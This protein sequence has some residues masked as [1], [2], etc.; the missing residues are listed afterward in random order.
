VEP[1]TLW[2]TADAVL[3]ELPRNGVEIGSLHLDAPGREAKSRISRPAFEGNGDLRAK[4][5]AGHAKA[6]PLAPLVSALAAWREE[7][8]RVFLV[9][10]TA[11]SGDR[12]QRLLERYQRPLPL[13]PAGLPEGGAAGGTAPPDA[14]IVVGELS[15][16]FRLPGERVVYVTETEIFGPRRRVQGGAARRREA[17]KAFDTRL[18]DL[19]PGDYL[20]H[21]D[22][23]VA[24]YHG[25]VHL[26][27]GE[28]A[29]DFLQLGFAGNDR[30]YLPVRR[31]HLV[32]RYVG[33]DDTPPRLDRLGGAAWVRAKGK[34]AQAVRAMARELLEVHAARQVMRRKPFG[35]ADGGYE[36]FAARFP[37][38]ET[39]DQQN[40]IEETL[41][42]L[43]SPHPMDRLICGDV[44]YG[45]TEVAMRAAHRVVTGGKQVAVLVPTTVLALQHYQTFKE[46]FRD[47]PVLI[48]EL[49]RFK[50]PRAQ[51]AIVA[52][53]AEGKVDIV[54]GTHRLLGKDVAYRDLGLLVVDEE[55][56]FGVRHK[57]QMKQIR[58]LVDV[59]TLTA[60]PN[61]RTLHMGLLGLRDLS[62][63]NTPPE[64]RL[65]IRTFVMHW[66]GAEAA[67]AIRREI[68][69]GGQVFFVHNRVRTIAEA[70]DRVKRLVPEARIAVAHGQMPERQL[71]RVMLAFQKGVADV[72]VST[73]IIENGL[74]LPNVNTLLVDRA[75]RFGLAQLYQMRG[76][77]GRG[78][79]RAYA[80]LFIPRASA[81][82]GDA[83]KR[84]VALQELVELGSAFKL[85]AQDLEIRGAGNLLGANQSGHI[86]AVGY[87]MFA[88][89]LE[90]AVREMRGQPLEEEV[91]VEIDLKIPAFIP[92]AFVADTSQRLAIYR[93]LSLARSDE[94]VADIEWDMTDRYGPIP[95]AGIDL[96]EAVRVRLLARALHV[97]TLE[98]HGRELLITW[99]D[100]TGVDPARVIALA[101]ESGG[102]LRLLPDNRLRL[103]MPG[104]APKTVLESAK[105]MLQSLG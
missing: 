24:G 55:Q 27:V 15:A 59:L 69:R 12:L 64:D 54:I 49:S 45:K 53:L 60:T 90:R 47:Y 77:V 14:A 46:R 95:D 30:L 19:K 92:E 102:D 16:G 32:Q 9:A 22:H 85:A 73:S 74:D 70:A 75:D 23:G 37:Y 79:H 48:E 61:P 82:S 5:E 81:I 40:A 56:R 25:L 101:Q 97:K 51:R 42:D 36:E 80:Y 93:R 67:E 84:L 10:A 35:P 96:L 72:L 100:P 1:A 29:G 44:G 98:R 68:A 52:G 66:D 86:A 8:Q 21:R 89:L 58:K 4:L 17:A 39:A 63:I 83:R 38:E 88:D 57:E 99:S 33:A 87:E 2:R 65:A 43:E 34:A 11:G 103:Y 62:V 104:K 6:L 94:E 3:S 76:R 78:A 13:R 50:S 31:V 28:E 105:K 20:V 91:D 71:E 26:A 7:G 18:E 41:A